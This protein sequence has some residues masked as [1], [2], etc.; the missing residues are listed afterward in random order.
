M[1]RGRRSEPRRGGWLFGILIRFLC[2]NWR[3]GRNVGGAKKRAA[4]GELLFGNIDAFLVWNLTGGPNGGVHVT[5]VTNA[6]RTQ[7]LDLKTLDWDAGL[8]GTFE[9][10]RAML[11][12][13][14]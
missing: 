3:A 12:K 14:R 7:L 11:P 6:S 10:P 5:D 13:V 2:G 8:L 4:A 9:I 1:W